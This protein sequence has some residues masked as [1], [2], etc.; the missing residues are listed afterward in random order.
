MSPSVRRLVRVG[1]A[2]VL[3][4]LLAACS[5]TASDTGKDSHGGG[6]S[7]STSAPAG[8]SGDIMF[9][10]MMIPHHEQAID[11][12]E[13]ALA[14]GDTSDEVRE[15]A[16][17]IKQAQD[18]EI[19]SMTTWLKGWGASTTPDNGHGDM[20]TGMMSDADVAALEQAN[21]AAFD[22]KWVSMMIEHHEG[23]I[24]MARDVLA[25]TRD[26]EV[27]AL[28]DAVVKAQSEEITTMRT[29]S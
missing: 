25:T 16:T 3:S 8:R 7:S 27:K 22:E 28:A 18:P 14:K 10:Q 12:A 29:L 23:A 24:E 17:A 15:L 19:Q 20:G 21:G 1:T 2:L 26:P 9:A 13:I 5:S 4:G 11:M 6:D